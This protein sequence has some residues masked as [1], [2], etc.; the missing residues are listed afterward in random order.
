MN[1][2]EGCD[3]LFIGGGRAWCNVSNPC[4]L[5]QAP[6]DQTA[7][8]SKVEIMGVHGGMH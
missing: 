2:E 4:D 1:G 8:K 7:I 5:H 3:P 6:L